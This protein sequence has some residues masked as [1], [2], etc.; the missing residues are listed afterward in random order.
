[1][2]RHQIETA[3]RVWQTRLKLDHWDIRVDW[4]N[5]SGGGDVASSEIQDLYDSVTLRFDSRHGDWKV[6]YGTQTVIHELL[7]LHERDLA[8]AVKSVKPLIGLPAYEVFWQRYDHEREGLIDRV[9]T[10][11]YETGKG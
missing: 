10:I 1:M 7:H 8:E 5:P 11:L 3:V 9:A 4:D 6:P 2:T